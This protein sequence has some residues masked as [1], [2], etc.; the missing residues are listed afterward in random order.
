MEN[1][2]LK[3]FL[4]THLG[5]LP[6]ELREQIYTELLATPPSYAGHDFDAVSPQSRGSSSVPSKFVHIK[7]SWFQVMGTCRQIYVESRPIFFAS[8]CYYFGTP[9]ER[10]PCVIYSPFVRRALF[11]QDTITALCLRDFIHTLPLYDKE[12]ID[13]IM[14]NPNDFRSSRP[15]Q[16]LETRTF[17]SL[18][19]TTLYQFRYLKN[20]RTISLCFQVGEEMHSVNLVYLLTEMRRGLVEF[21]YT[22]HWLIRPQNPE[23]PWNLQCACFV[24]ASYGSGKDNEEISYSRRRIEFDVTDIDSR[25]PELKEGDERYVEVQIRR[26]A[27]E[28]PAPEPRGSEFDDTVL[29]SI[30]IVNGLFTQ[31]PHAHETPLEVSQDP[32]A[33]NTLTE[34]SQQDEEP[35]GLRSSL[36]STDQSTFFELND[37]DSDDP[38]RAADADQEEIHTLSQP[39]SEDD[40]N[41]Q[42]GTR[43]DPPA[44]DPPEFTSDALTAHEA[45]AA[46][47]DDRSSLLDTQ[48]EGD[49]I[50]PKPGTSSQLSYGQDTHDW[51]HS[52]REIAESIAE[53]NQVQLGPSDRVKGQRRRFKARFQSSVSSQPLPD[54]SNTPRPYTDEEMKSHKKWQEQ[55]TSRKQKA[56]ESSHPDEK[57]PSPTEKPRDLPINPPCVQ[58]NTADSHESSGILVTMYLAGV[59]FLLLLMLA[60]NAYYSERQSNASSDSA[61]SGDHH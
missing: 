6:P 28:I 16:E 52:Y 59:L 61:S 50:E 12:T 53:T 43:S 8:K 38:Q 27:V 29:R 26:P 39:L 42:A 51:W 56:I 46:T 18:K 60:I 34:Q 10:A 32:A 21:V 9:K 35:S 1:T 49:L 31:D 13:G 5:R 37:E 57:I 54:I 11:R 23:D 19:T 48:N 41:F 4:Q 17:T 15:R 30:S 47:G 20:L 3:P 55:S 7:A 40:P 58:S 22:S 14:S 33:D 24:F 36:T 45:P 25:A 2:T 44:E